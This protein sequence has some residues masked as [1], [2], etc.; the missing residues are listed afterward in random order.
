MGSRIRSTNTSKIQLKNPSTNRS[1]SSST[2]CSRAPG[3][4]ITTTFSPKSRS[5]TQEQVQGPS[6]TGLQLLARRGLAMEGGSGTT[7]GAAQPFPR[8][9]SP[10][11]AQLLPPP[12]APPP[13]REQAHSPRTSCSKRNDVELGW[14]RTED[15]RCPR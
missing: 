5:F 4:N 10:N 2:T 14:G 11:S 8:T 3:N 1:R 12:P 13:R 6:S 7:H 15:A 9:F